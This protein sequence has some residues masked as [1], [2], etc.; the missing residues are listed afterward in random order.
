MAK[1]FTYRL[2]DVTVPNEDVERSEETLLTPRKEKKKIH[3]NTFAC[4]EGFTL[5]VAI[6]QK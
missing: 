4:E 1:A 5:S 3:L 6:S 2:K